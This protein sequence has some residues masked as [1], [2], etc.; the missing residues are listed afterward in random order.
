LGLRR[1]GRSSLNR[2][3]GRIK[4]LTDIQVPAKIIRVGESANL[5][6]MVSAVSCSASS[7][8]TV[9]PTDFSANESFHVAVENLAS[10][11][12]L[13][14]GSGRWFYERARGSYGAAEFASFAKAETLVA[15][16]HTTTKASDLKSKWLHDPAT[17]K[18]RRGGRPTAPAGDLVK[19]AKIV[20]E[21]RALNPQLEATLVLTTNQEP[22]VELVRD[23]PR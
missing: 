23:L 18:P 7:Q 1:Q 8:N 19:T 15:V 6:N 3:F 16:H 22:S 20:A 21:E 5:A 4:Y 13:P 17:V 12:W 14:S 2:R 9:Q 10:N 11:I